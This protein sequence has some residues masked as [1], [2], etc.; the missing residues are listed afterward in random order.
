MKRTK[1]NLLT[2]L[3]AKL[4]N[5]EYI[6]ELTDSKKER[7]YYIQL[8]EKRDNLKSFIWMLEDKNWFDD[9]W[10]IFLRKEG[11]KWVAK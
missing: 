1:H 5:T 7:K 4:E 9:Q 2:L 3:K 11:K 8:S 6:L 10:H